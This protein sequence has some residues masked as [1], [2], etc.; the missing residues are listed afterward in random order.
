MSKRKFYFHIFIILLF[1]N[2][3]KSKNKRSPIFKL[4][5][6]SIFLILQNKS[7][8]VSSTLI[9]RKVI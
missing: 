1:K 9:K 3:L 5:A 7:L 6:D 4:I 2:N 8:I